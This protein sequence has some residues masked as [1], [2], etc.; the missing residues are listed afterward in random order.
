LSEAKHRT[1]S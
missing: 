1:I